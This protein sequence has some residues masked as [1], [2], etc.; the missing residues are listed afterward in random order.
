MNK[1]FQVNFS[2]TQ[3]SYELDMETKKNRTKLVYTINDPDS[4]W[5]N[6][7]VRCEQIYKFKT[8]FQRDVTAEIRVHCK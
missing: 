3:V 6:A 4:S 5:D 7:L 8:N 2:R 1:F